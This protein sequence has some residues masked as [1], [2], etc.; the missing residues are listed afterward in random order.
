[1]QGFESVPLFLVPFWVTPSTTLARE[2]PVRGDHHFKPVL[3]RV[4][5]RL[6]FIPGIFGRRY[7]YVVP[8]SGQCLRSRC[9]FR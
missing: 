9:I 4:A 3:N 6:F 5:E 8:L 2:L 7:S 1:M